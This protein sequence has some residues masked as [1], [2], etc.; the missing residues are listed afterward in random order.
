MQYYKKIDIDFY[1]VIIADALNYIK[2]QQPDIYARKIN[3]T[4]NVL[5]LSELKKFCPK[6]DLSFAKYNITC[7]FAV[8][9]V[10]YKIGDIGIHIDSYPYGDARINIPLLNTKGTY[11]KFFT[12]GIFKEIV[13]PLTNIHSLRLHSGAGLTQVD[14]VEIDKTTVIRVNEPH[15]VFMNSATVPRITLSLGFDKDPIFLLED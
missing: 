15:C 1:D 3:A 9:F 10:M 5:D 2:E 13:N 6:L 11:T 12:G 8:A 14:S 4:Y 7:N